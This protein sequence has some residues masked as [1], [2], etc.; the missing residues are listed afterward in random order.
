MERNPM[1]LGVFTVLFGDRP[2]EAALDRIVEA[3]L[4]CVEI[5]TGNYPGNAHCEPDVLLE[6]GSALR[7]FQQAIQSR[8]LSISAL[9]CHGNTLHPRADVARAS[10]A[11]FTSTLELAQR[12]DVTCVNLFSCCPGDSDTARSRNWVN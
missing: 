4:E 9:S 10:Q 2:L 11:V 12:L 6:D 1:K 8:H 5:G 7:A 3:G